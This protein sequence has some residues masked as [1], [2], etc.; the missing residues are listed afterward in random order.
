MKP[1][2]RELKY[3]LE[4]YLLFDKKI[5]TDEN[6]W[7]LVAQHFFNYFYVCK[8]V[9]NAY[10]KLTFGSMLIVR[11]DMKTSTVENLRLRRDEI[12]Q[13]ISK[14][15]DEVDLLAHRIIKE[16]SIVDWRFRETVLRDCLLSAEEDLNELLCHIQA[17]IACVTG[18]DGEE[19]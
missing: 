9:K 5:E 10:F 3:E 19:A 7:V 15:R 8:K 18:G 12:E 14:A 6:D 16:T 13:A 2:L 4:D 17:A 1:D 11:Y